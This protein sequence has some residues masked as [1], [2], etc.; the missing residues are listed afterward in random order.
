MYISVFPFILSHPISLVKLGREPGWVR[1]KEG[2]VEEEEVPR[3]R[4]EGE[5][6]EGR[7]KDGG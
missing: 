6:G 7:E 1:G 4:N 3:E 2:R 5:G